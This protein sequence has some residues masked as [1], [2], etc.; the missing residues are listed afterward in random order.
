MKPGNQSF[1]TRIRLRS[2]LYLSNYLVFQRDSASMA[3]SG[4]ALATIR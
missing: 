1:G 3:I 4:A 2:L